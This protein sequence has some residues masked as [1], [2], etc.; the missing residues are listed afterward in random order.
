VV[1]PFEHLGP[2]EERDFTAGITMEIHSRLAAVPS[3]GVISRTTAVQYDLAGKTLQQIGEDLGVDY[4]LEGTVLW[5]QPADGA[6]RVRVHPQLVQ[7][8]D[9]TPLWS[10]RYEQELTEVFRVQ[11]EIA[12]QVIQGLEGELLEPEQAVRGRPTDNLEAYQIYL[13]G[14]DHLYVL[15]PGRIERAAMKF[16][17]ALELDPDFVLAQARLAQALVV[18]EPARAEE[19]A[20]RALEMAPDLPEAHLAMGWYHYRVERDDDRALEE[21]QIAEKDLPNDWEIALVTGYI[22]RRRG[23]YEEA[24]YWMERAA[25]LQPN[26]PSITVDLGT[27]F[28]LSRHFEEADFYYDRTITLAP[29]Q[30]LAYYAYLLNTFNYYAWEKTTEKARL[31]L[32][33]APPSTECDITLAWTLLEWFDRNYSAMAERIAATSEEYCG[34]G[35]SGYSTDLLAGLAYQRMDRPERARSFLESACIEIEKYLEEH[36]DSPS[37]RSNLGLVYAA[38]GRNDEAVREGLR[39]VELWPTSEDAFQGPEFVLLLAK[40]YAMVGE[41]E[42][43]LDRLEYL[44]SLET[45]IL[46][47]APLHLDP[48]W[49]PLRE[50]PRFQNL[51]S[52]IP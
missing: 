21:L 18:L 51:L 49:D 36:P 4:V 17:R 3:L 31:L 24:I 20:K 11:S 10:G 40:I 39:A 38:L 37:R 48:T 44:Q 1:L 12:G 27:T 23:R 16:E 41:Q 14:L 26:D 22:H 29:N 7:V 34:I 6:N 28:W 9:D 13:Q 47:M 32:E 42:R 45:A 43:A 35:A 5:E 15:E 30:E 8:S 46:S 33:S 19:M 50:N 2:S 25:I 52:R